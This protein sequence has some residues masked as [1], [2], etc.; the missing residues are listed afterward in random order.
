MATLDQLPMGG[1]VVNIF[2]QQSETDRQ[3]AWWVVG[4][5]EP[6]RTQM[7]LKPLVNI[8]A[9]AEIVVDCQE[10]PQGVVLESMKPTSFSF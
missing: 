3:I 9:V 2:A 10:R 6:L 7:A 8:M 1:T 4:D 5:A